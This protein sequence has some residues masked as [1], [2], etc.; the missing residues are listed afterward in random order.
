M[1]KEATQFKPGKS[2]NAAGRPSRV[3]SKKEWMD[4]EVD[5]KTKR[6]ILK[7]A[8]DKALEGKPSMIELI[9]TRV[10]PPVANDDA[11]EIDLRDKSHKERADEIFSALSDKRITPAQAHLLFATLCDNVKLVEMTEII[12]RIKALEQSQI[13]K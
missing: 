6:R 2:G 12:D 9:L 13:I 5:D 4:K 3:L 10:L 7:V 1:G 8:I 11:I